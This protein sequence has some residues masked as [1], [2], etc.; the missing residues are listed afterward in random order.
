M[1]GNNKEYKAHLDIEAMISTFW[2]F[3]IALLAFLP[4]IAFFTFAKQLSYWWIILFFAY[5]G[6]LSWILWYIMN[7]RKMREARMY[8]GNEKYYEMYP[9]EKKRDER[10]KKILY[11]WNRILGK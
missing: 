1:K 11:M 3:L 2:L 8:L 9:S 7:R 6:F 10:I 5:Y 4:P